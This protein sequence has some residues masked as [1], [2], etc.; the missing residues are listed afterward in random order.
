MLLGGAPAGAPQ[1]AKELAAAEP[2][3]DEPATV[4]GG[5]SPAPAPRGAPVKVRSH[6]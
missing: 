4:S 3:T 1:L 6:V 2:S 5:T